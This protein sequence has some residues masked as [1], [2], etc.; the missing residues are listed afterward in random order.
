[1]AAQAGAVPADLAER[2]AAS[3][4]LRNILTHEYV[5]VDLKIVAGSIPLVRTGYHDYVTGLARYLA[6]HS[7]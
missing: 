6:R 7:Q 4:G 3:A 1:L 5:S 2:L